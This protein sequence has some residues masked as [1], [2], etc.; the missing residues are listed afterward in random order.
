M[1]NLSVDARVLRL[2]LFTDTYAPQVNGV[3]RTLER[4]I[5]AVAERGGVAQVF[6]VDDPGATDTVGVVRYPSRSFWAYDE[7]K[8]AW[9]SR[10]KVRDEVLKFA[11][12]IV[13]SAT[14]FGV[15][16]AGRRVARALEIPFV[17]SYHTSFS[18]YARY[19]KLGFLSRPGWSF[20]RWFHNGGLRTYCPTQAI[21]REITDRGF[22]ECRVWSRGV[23]C[24]RFAPAYRSRGLRSQMG[25]TDQTVVVGYVGRLAAEKGLKM[26]LEAIQKLEKL[27][28]GT[29]RF[30]AAG[31]GP[32]ADEIRRA[33]PPGSWLPGKLSGQALSE[34]Y[35]SADIF[36]FPSTTDTFGNVLLESMASGVPALGADV[37]PTREIL[38]NG[39]GW[40]AR[41][42]DSDD[43]ARVL[44]E[45]VDDRNRISTARGSAL[46]FARSKSWSVIWDALIQDYLTLQRQPRQ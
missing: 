9:P 16:L 25:A 5:D 21:Q 26:A 4:L 14:E 33:A 20:L 46:A 45:L 30:M 29:T 10:S 1:G 12:T 13:H 8:L 36:L 19:Y 28:P 38:A 44:A 3:S 11:P 2:A 22:R 34:A 15:G 39:R 27:R 40:L 17:S 7:L 35:A 37:G 23:D 42:N 24:D 41:P 18:A 6:T 43:F 31:D 32:F